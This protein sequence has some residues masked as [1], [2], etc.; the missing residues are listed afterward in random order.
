MAVLFQ[1]PILNDEVSLLLHGN[2]EENN[3]NLVISFIFDCLELKKSL[4]IKSTFL[5]DAD[6]G[7]NKNINCHQILHFIY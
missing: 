3:T 7:Q 1:C 6:G 5:S 2:F 4:N